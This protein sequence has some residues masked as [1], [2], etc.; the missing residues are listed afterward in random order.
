MQYNTDLSLCYSLSL[1][2]SASLVAKATLAEFE[3]PEF[4]PLSTTQLLS[5][6]DETDPPNEQIEKLKNIISCILYLQNQ[7][8]LSLPPMEVL[9][10]YNA[11]PLCILDRALEQHNHG[12]DIASNKILIQ[13]ALDIASLLGIEAQDKEIITTVIEK[14]LFF[15][16]QLKDEVRV[17][18][19]CDK[20]LERLQ[21]CILLYI[22]LYRILKDTYRLQT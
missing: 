1:E 14:V 10:L 8:S 17:I 11:S 16:L 21:V 22:I 9:T 4:T 3:N 2:A 7:L 15:C 19:M 20:V 18:E 12:N 6:L 13:Q 5:V